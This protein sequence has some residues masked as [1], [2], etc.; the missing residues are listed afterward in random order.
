MDT[1]IKQLT[2]QGFRFKKSL[3]QNFITDT[4]LLHAI[5]ADACV[6]SDDR[7]IEVGA[8]A[9][10]LTRALAA[11]AKSVTAFEVDTSL[12]SV[13]DKLSAEH[14][15]VRV[16]YLDALKADIAAVTDN[17]PFKLVA[18]LPYYITTPVI[19]H[20]LDVPNLISLTVML[21]KE[22]AQRF[23][24]KE[25]T[26]EY[27][28]VTAQLRAY[29]EPRITRTVSRALFTPPPNVDSA[30]VHFELQKKPGVADF[31]HLK[32]LIACAFAMRRKTLVN[33]LCAGFALGKEQAAAFLSAAG[34]AEGVRGETLGIEQFIALSN[35]MVR[36]SGIN[37]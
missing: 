29:G 37:I 10:S 2:S 23:V 5:V 1:D 16:L 22:V 15:N 4:N 30:V 14:G 11:R 24:A 18:N 35:I 31:A 7:V 25:N 36:A 20:F 26:S 21:Q 27:G 9:G 19:F 12:A 6:C 3:G 28:A 8:G 33:N 13:L 34:L 17:A 32:R